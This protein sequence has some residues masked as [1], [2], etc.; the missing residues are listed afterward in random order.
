MTTF[1]QRLFSETAFDAENPRVCEIALVAGGCSELQVEQTGKAINSRLGECRLAYHR[2][3][4]KLAEQLAL[5][6]QP[7]RERWAMIGPGM[8]SAITK[9]IWR[10]ARGNDAVSKGRPG[11][12]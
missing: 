7:L 5:R 10:D 9:Q 6:S 12:G 1:W 4:P 11:L 3:F 8:L 2:R